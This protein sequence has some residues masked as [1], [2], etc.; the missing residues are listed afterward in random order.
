MGR[1]E[2]PLK[3]RVLPLL[4][5]LLAGCRTP[6]SKPA[7]RTQATFQASPS[8]RVDATLPEDPEVAAF[9]APRTQEVRATF[10]LPLIQASTPLARGRDGA[11]N[12][13][14]YWICD[15][16]RARAEKIVGRPVPFAIANRGGIRRDLKAGQLKV[17]DIFEVMPFENELIL[18]ELT[19]AEVV[20][21]MR[22][23]LQ[24][25][26]GEPISGVKATVIGGPEDAQMSLTWEDG[27]PIDPAATVLVATSDY[28]YGSGDTMPTLKKGRK[29]F[30]SG[31]TIRQVLLDACKDLKDQGRTLAAPQ[32]GRYQIPASLLE[33]LARRQPIR[34][35]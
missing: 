14:G 1:R 34:I 10:E 2:L 8:T 19:G 27:R 21:V 32:G 18:I 35:R 33:T 17:G 7:P 15:A 29:P 31:L 6:E 4:L 16:L 23:G 20:Q 11:E 5:L 26:G 28:L 13:L 3:L 22:E 24:S 30:T 25:R 12:L 9:I